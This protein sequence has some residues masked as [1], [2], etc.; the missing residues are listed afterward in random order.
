MPTSHN[1]TVDRKRLVL[2]HSI[3]FGT[4]FN[5]GEVIAR[6]LSEACKNDKGILAFPC[7]ISALYRHHGV[8]TYNNDKNTIFCMGWDRKQYM[9]KM[10]VAD[11]VP[12]QVAMPTPAHFEETEAH[13]PA[14]NLEEPAGSEPPT[15]PAAPQGSPSAAS[16]AQ[17]SYAAA[18]S[19][20]P[21]P[22]P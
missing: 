7:L 17:G 1:Q 21:P 6:E 8:P 14:A 18:S 2:I 3:I 20:P 19:P 16:V 9:R 10:D 11:A 4:K 5:I 15:P 12:I 13:V 22:D